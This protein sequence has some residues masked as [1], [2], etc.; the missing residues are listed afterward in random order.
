MAQ[1]KTTFNWR[2][3]ILEVTGI[4]FAVLLALWLE[5]WREDRELQEQANNNLE[6]VV[7]E[8]A[9][10]RSDLVESIALHEAYIEALTAA[11][12]DKDVS[13]QNV[14]PY[15]KVD[16]STTSDAAWQSARLS[17]SVGRIPPEITMQ[18]AALYDTQAYYADYLNFFFQRYIDL[19]SDIEDGPKPEVATR[20]FVR[21]L[22]VTN[23][24]ADQL[25]RRYDRFLEAQG[26]NVDA[27]QS[28]GLDAG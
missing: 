5:G 20:K 17:S 8:V 10:N 23:A 27:A 9:R 14:G 22:G 3:A 7:A 13:L 18:L 2:S 6:R 25:L 28:Q 11:L 4:V 16:G 21:H 15:L 19:I 26:V 24:L 12:N 1:A